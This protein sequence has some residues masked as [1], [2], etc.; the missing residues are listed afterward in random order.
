MEL[1]IEILDIMNGT[2]NTIGIFGWKVGE[3]SY[4]CSLP[5]IEFA[6]QY[7]NV[8]ILTPT[9]PI[10]ERIDLIIIPG[11]VDINPL[12]YGQ[13]PYWQT[14]KS[15]PIKEYFDDYILPEYITIGT[16][17]FGICRGIQSLA[18]YFGAKL[19]QH[20]YHETNDKNRYDT[21]HNI[22]LEEPFEQEYLDFHKG[23]RRM[24]KI[25]VNSLHHQCVSAIDLP[26]ELE[27]IG[28]YKGKFEVGSIEAIRHRELPIYGVQY[29]PEELLGDPLSDYIMNK[30]LVKEP[31]IY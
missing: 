21:V 2:K 22:S 30:L 16:P 28:T 12:R 23:N 18:V 14:S 29:H 4:G 15:D 6:S 9:E 7:G 3:N 31:V 17:I 11:G 26:D 19:V 25:E 27:I 5:Y 13:V 24:L 10:D 1:E 20:M 8:R